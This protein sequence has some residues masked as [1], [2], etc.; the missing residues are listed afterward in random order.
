MAKFKI[1]VVEDDEK[2]LE[3]D[4]MLVTASGYRVC[5]MRSGTEALESVE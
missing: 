2:L 1:M 5:G 3:L 4:C